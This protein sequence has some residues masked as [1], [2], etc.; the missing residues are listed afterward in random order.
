MTAKTTSE[1]VT[2]LR[3]ARAARGHVRRD[4]YATLDEHDK[5]RERLKELRREG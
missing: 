5:L 2:K 3:A 4:Y 1:R